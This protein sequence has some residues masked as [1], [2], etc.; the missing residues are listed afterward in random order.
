[1]DLA[2]RVLLFCIGCGVGFILGFVVARLRTIEIKLD[3]VQTEVHEVDEIMKHNRDEDGSGRMPDFEHVMLILVLVI[4]VLAA[5][6]TSRV[7]NRL[8]ETV[9]CLTDYNTNQVEVLDARDDSVTRATD[10]EIAL[11]KRYEAL[12]VE[13]KTIPPDELPRLRNEING[14]IITYRKQLERTQ[15]T[16]AEYEYDDPDV[17]KDCEGDTK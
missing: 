11:W 12:F 6:S 7:N 16:R 3:I 8:D 4:V 10:A 2:E 13:A 15:Q 1:M 14:A 9:T 17:Y 5:F